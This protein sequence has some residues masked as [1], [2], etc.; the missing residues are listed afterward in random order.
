MEK[1]LKVKYSTFKTDLSFNDW[2][3]EVNFGKYYTEP[4]PYFQ[5]NV[6]R[7]ETSTLY[8]SVED[9]FPKVSFKDKI[10]NK[11]KINLKSKWRE[12]TN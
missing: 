2:V 8:Q 1:K 11:F 5:G 10:I 6:T 12:K 4:T 9:L 7:R 3:K